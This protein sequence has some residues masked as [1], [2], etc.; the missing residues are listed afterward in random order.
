MAIPTFLCRPCFSIKMKSVNLPVI[1]P[2]SPIISLKGQAFAA[3]IKYSNAL[4]A[5]P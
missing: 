1:T 2:L 3:W 5:T 4:S